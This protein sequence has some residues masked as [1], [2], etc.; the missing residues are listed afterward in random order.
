VYDAALEALENRQ[1]RQVTIPEIA[2]RANVHPTSIYR[3]WGTLERLLVEAV[4]EQSEQHLPIP[5]TGRL[6]TDLIQ[7]VEELTLYADNPHAATLL[8]AMAATTND[9]PEMEALRLQFWES[10]MA[11]AS[12][13]VTRAIERGE[14]PETTDARWV[15]ELLIAPIH[16]RTLLSHQ[17]L[18]AA[19]PSRLADAAIAAATHSPLPRSDRD[20]GRGRRG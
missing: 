17:P 4:L 9:D 20:A 1:A 3:R 19:L 14:V 11:T 2:A 13:M 7:F 5:D 6:R 12:V 10:R 15:L 8:R 16:F 18:D